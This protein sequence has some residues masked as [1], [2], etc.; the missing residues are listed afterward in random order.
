MNTTQ[1]ECFMEVANCLNFSRAAER[2]CI[3]QP[4]VSHQIST[5]EDELGV[6]LFQRSSKSV[7]L[8]QEGFLFTQYAGEI[9]RLSGVSKARVKESRQKASKRLIIGCRTQGELRILGPAMKQLRETEPQVLPVLKLVPFDSLENQLLEGDLH[10]MFTFRESATPKARYRE[11]AKCPVVCICNSTHPLAGST[12]LTLQQLKQGGQIAVGRPPSIPPHLFAILNQVLAG[13]ETSQ[14]LFC[15][16]QETVFPLV[17][18]GYAFAV[19]ADFP[20][21]RIPGLEYIPIPEFGTL[22]FGVAYLSE[23]SS[24]FLR[25]FITLMERSIPASFGG[26]G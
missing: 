3:T 6:K 13:R 9:L 21:A 4:A 10:M 5:L 25:Q 20:H 15:D 23:K 8:T 24:P 11:I 14:I 22:S 18:A 2:L 1:L 12:T 7:R 19:M 16:S 26:K 17:E